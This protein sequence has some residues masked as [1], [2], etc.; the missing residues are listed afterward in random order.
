MTVGGGPHPPSRVGIVSCRFGSD[1]V[2]V[3]AG[4]GMRR[5]GDACVALVFFP[6]AP[7]PS[8]QGYASFPTPRNFSPTDPILPFHL[9]PTRV[10]GSHPQLPNTHTLTNE[11]P[12]ILCKHN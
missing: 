11:V 6:Q 10:R 4:V 12:K 3:G 8:C 2:P 9:I 5:G 7:S 1:F